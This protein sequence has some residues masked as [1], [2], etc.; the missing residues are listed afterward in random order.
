MIEIIDIILL[1][2]L[3]IF[4]VSGPCNVFHGNVANIKSQNKLNLYF[5]L[6]INLNLLLILSILPLKLS[7]YVNYFYIILIFFF[8]KNYLYNFKINN[9]KDFF[10]VFLIFLIIYFIISIDISNK[11]NLSWD[12]KWFWY[13]KSLYFFQ[14]NTFKDLT[15]YPYNDFHPHFGSFIWAF[16]RKISFNQYE[17]FGRLFYLFLYL[18][19]LILITSNLFKKNIYNAI[20]FLII[21][22]INYKY[23]YLSGLQEVLLF[24]LLIIIS[25]LILNYI[26][27][28]NILYLYFVALSLNLII[29][30]KA[31]GIAFFA[32][33]ILCINLIKKLN[34]NHRIKFNILTLL[35]LVFKIAIFKIYNVKLN[36]QPYYFDYIASLNLDIIIYKVVNISTYFLYHSLTNIILLLLPVIL[37]LKF[38]KIFKDEFL[39]FN[40][41]FYILNIIFIFSAYLLRDMEIVYSLKTTIDRLI[42]TSSGFY[43]L[44]II[45]YFK[46]LSYRII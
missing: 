36:N 21:I 31:E 32:I 3:F 11:L 41:Y 26:I 38:K 30:T 20:I 4:F 45:D 12:S 6:L 22:I 37:L 33:T 39:K 35:L 25:K 2:F 5:N 42:F 46:K 29:W 17:Y 10:P 40:F 28:R 9:I 44:L 7:I 23:Y 24:S 27:F 1:F 34:F 19:S 16:F 8:V 14:D 15:S 43:L 18:G 13:I